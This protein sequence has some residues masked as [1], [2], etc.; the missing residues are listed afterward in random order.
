[1]I[2]WFWD[3][4]G[5][6]IRAVIRV[7]EI[8]RSHGWPLSKATVGSSRPVSSYGGPVA[9]VGYTYIYEGGYFSGVHQEPF[10]LRSSA[11]EY[12]ARFA[13]CNSIVVRIK[14]GQPETSIVCDED[15]VPAL[16]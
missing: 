3:V 5:Y 14:P 16:V 11:E 12:A 7:A 2:G 1:M 4:I 13:T 15:Q 8:R 9:E 6:L 10:L